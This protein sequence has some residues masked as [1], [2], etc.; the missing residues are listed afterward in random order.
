MSSVLRSRVAGTL[1]SIRVR[2]QLRGL[3]VTVWLADQEAEARAAAERM[4]LDVLQVSRDDLAG[5]LEALLGLEHEEE[6]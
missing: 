1:L 4:G 5:R 3:P 2:Q 6:A